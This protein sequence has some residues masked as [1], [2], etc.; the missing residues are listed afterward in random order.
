MERAEDLDVL[1]DERLVQVADDRRVVGDLALVLL[2]VEDEG[3]V[4]TT[5]SGLKFSRSGPPT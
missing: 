4:E 1:V 5:K 2:R 3:Q